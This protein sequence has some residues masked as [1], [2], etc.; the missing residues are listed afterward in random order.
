MKFNIVNQKNDVNVAQ[1]G[2]ASGM[3]CT[4]RQGAPDRHHATAK[5]EK[6]KKR[7]RCSKSQHGTWEHCYSME[8]W[9]TWKKKW[10]VWNSISSE[11]QKCVGKEVEVFKLTTTLSFSPAQ[12]TEG[13]WELDWYSTKSG[14]RSWPDF[15]RYLNESFWPNYRPR[16][17][18]WILSKCMLLQQHQQ[19]VRSRH[20]TMMSKQPLTNANPEI[21][22]W[23]LVTGMRK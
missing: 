22:Q 23:S 4:T 6:Q 16:Q 17:C 7:R 9:K 15:G 20:F 18:H 5:M 13:R 11:Y 21:S 2:D 8:S 14:Q 12:K 1:R 3:D 19:I 10:I